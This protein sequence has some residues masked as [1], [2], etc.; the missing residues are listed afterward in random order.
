[1]NHIRIEH[2]LDPRAFKWLWAKYVVAPNL[3]QHC[4]A[5]LRAESVTTPAGRRSAYSQKLSKTSNPNL[6]SERLLLMD[7]CRSGVVRPIYICGVSS[8]GYATRSNYPH[9]LHAALWPLDGASDVL[10]FEEW[11]LRVTNARFTRIPQLEE[12]PKE[13]Q[14]LPPQFLTCRIFRWAACVL[15]MALCAESPDQIDRFCT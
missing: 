6:R 2:N 11:E 5:C 4:T 9:N 3:G 12:M 8:R 14:P 7:E 15:P 10:R 1:M 13:L